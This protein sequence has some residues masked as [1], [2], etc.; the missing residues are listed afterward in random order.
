MSSHD[1]GTEPLLDLA[2][3]TEETAPAPRPT[4]WHRLRRGTGWLLALV[5]SALAVISLWPDLLAP[6][7]ALSEIYPF[8]QVIALRSVMALALAVLGVI[9]TVAAVVRTVRR[10]G[11]QRTS[12]VGIVLV[13]VAGMHLWA[14]DQR[15]LDLHAALADRGITTDSASW[16]GE[17][18]VYSFNTYKSQAGLVDLGVSVRG[19]GADV[20]VLPETD[21][22]YGV[23]LAQLLAQDGYSFRVFSSIGDTT[24]GIDPAT[25]KDPSALGSDTVATTVLVSTGLGDYERSDRPAG[26]GSGNLVLTP[27]GDATLNGHA[28]PTI[29]GIHT[30]AP[31]G[32]GTRAGWL[33]SVS[34]AAA[35]C[36]DQGSATIVAGD[37]NATL[38][39]EPMR[40]LTGCSDVASTTG[41][42]GLATWPTSSRTA[43]LGA[44]ID[45]VFVNRTSWLPQ[46]SK[47][48]DVEGSDHRA[49][50]AVVSPR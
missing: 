17:V 34:A 48:L 47:V 43:L 49:V 3:V 35:Q 45:H 42:G 33:S 40:D 22:S 12:V 23:R 25:V 9:V 24:T 41:T 27:V 39:H 32:H 20:V 15:G 13:I 6:H 21:A 18:T 10:E 36:T 4:V 50:V 11:G 37:F 26:L 14:L 16:D 8:T 28:R 7:L 46:A 30:V 38:D 29:V 44:T 1:D 2:E 5:L 31:A 19:T